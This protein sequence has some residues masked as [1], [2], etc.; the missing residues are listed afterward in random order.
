MRFVIITGLSGA[1]KSNAIR[2]M[3]DIGFYCI[4]NMPPVLIPKLAELCFTSQGKLS[5]VAVVCDIRGGELFNEFYN[6]MET[7]KKCGYPFEL[8]F[9][10]ASDEVLIKR[11][12]ETRRKHP[13]GGEQI[14]SAIAK[15]RVLLS[16]AR[17]LADYKINTSVTTTE[18][19][20]NELVQVFSETGMK[21]GLII[22]I[23]SF[24]FKYGIP[25]DADL[26]F[27]VRF[28]PNPFY[29]EELRPLSG[30]D[31]AVSSYV[32]SFDQSVQFRDKL[33]D[34]LDFLLP[35]YAEEGK[36]Q[37]VIGIGCTGGK[38]RSVTLAI[39][40]HKHIK[41]FGY[42]TSLIHRDY[43]KDR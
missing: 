2:C 17:E 41:E 26:V 12:K 20:R 5:K 21:D 31:E 32:M 23:V 9:L 10:D 35:H 33:F 34:M 40:L 36:T 15:E 37:L 29:L 19:L 39:E 22:N 43:Q 38:H 1:G 6:C 24:G 14:S 13:L 3:E 25:I 30:M 8:L 16:G 4:D 27:D 18:Q 42:Q 28:L 11:Y 7:M